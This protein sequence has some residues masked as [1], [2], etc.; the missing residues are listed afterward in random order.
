MNGKTSGTHC[1]V[2]EKKN[3]C[4]GACESVDGNGEANQDETH[5]KETRNENSAL[6]LVRNG[7]RSNMVGGVE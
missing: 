5:G 1:D 4:H 3:N 7:E 6:S 2:D